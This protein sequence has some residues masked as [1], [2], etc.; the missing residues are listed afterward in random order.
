[1]NVVVHFMCKTAKVSD[2]THERLIKSQNSKYRIIR[3]RL[4][5]RRRHYKQSLTDYNIRKY[6]IKNRLVSF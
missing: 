5:T 1:M 6:L 4:N 3:R 2:S